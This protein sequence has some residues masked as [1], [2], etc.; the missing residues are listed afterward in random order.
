MPSKKPQMG[1]NA[2]GGDTLEKH[3][4]KIEKLLDDKAA[5]G[6]DIK[7]AMDSAAA[8]GLDKK[9]MR[10]MLK[11]RAMDEADRKAQEELRDVYIH[12]LGLGDVL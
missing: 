3:L 1:N 2:V 11:L 5:V 12:A 7:A 6:E 4:T 8:E 9:M 10:E